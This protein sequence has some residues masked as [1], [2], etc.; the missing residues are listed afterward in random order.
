[1]YMKMINSLALYLS[2]ARLG[3]NLRTDMGKMHVKKRID[4][5]LK[6]KFCLAIL[7]T[8]INIIWGTYT[9]I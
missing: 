2:S 1:M 3:V 7:E 8:I 9:I 4:Y 6:I 5:M